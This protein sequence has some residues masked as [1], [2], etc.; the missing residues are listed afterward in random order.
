[1]FWL[2][3]LYH[4]FSQRRGSNKYNK[5]WN[6]LAFANC[7]AKVRKQLWNKCWS[8][9]NGRQRWRTMLSTVSCVD[10]LLRRRSFTKQI[11]AVVLHIQA[12]SAELFNHCAMSNFNTFGRH[13]LPK[14]STQQDANNCYAFGMRESQNPSGNQIPNVPSSKPII[15][16][17]QNFRRG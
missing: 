9:L 3:F 13:Q 11:L 16:D 14:S 12:L 7:I 6:T 1:M 4:L 5:H 15:F 8:G 10:S 17:E 2:S